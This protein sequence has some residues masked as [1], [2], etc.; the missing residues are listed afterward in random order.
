MSDKPGG[1][2]PICGGLRSRKLFPSLDQED[3][4]ETHHRSLCLSQRFVLPE[5]RSSADVGRRLRLAAPRCNGRVNK[6][7]SFVAAEAKRKIWKGLHSDDM[8]FVSNISLGPP[9]VASLRRHLPSAFFDVHLMVSRPSQ[10]VEPMAAAGASQL[11][12]HFEAVGSS[13]EEASRLIGD[14]RSQGMRAGLSLKPGTDVEKIKDLLKNTPPDLLLIMTVEPGFGGQRFM[15]QVMPKIRNARALCPELDIQVDGGLDKNTVRDA[16]ENG[17]NVIVA[18]TSLYKCEAPR[19][20]MEY[21]RDQ[22]TGFLLLLLR[23][24]LLAVVLLLLFVVAVAAF[25]S[26]SVAAAAAAVAAVVLL[27]RVYVLER[28]FFLIVFSRVFCDFSQVIVAA[29]NSSC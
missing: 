21:M 27:T 18:G 28:A 17:A 23:L 20:L 16:A 26:A 11:T 6:T 15:H 5:R 29:Q 2:A 13:E 4:A 9:V 12:F 14:I 3:A 19:V 7:H 22:G 1:E 24:V 10:W 8:H 25:A